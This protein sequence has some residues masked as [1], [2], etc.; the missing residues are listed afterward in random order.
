[1][2]VRRL[3]GGIGNQFHQYALGRAMQARGTDVI[4]ST[5][6]F[7]RNA[8]LPRPFRLDRFHTILETASSS[9]KRGK[10][11][12]VAERGRRFNSALTKKDEIVVHGYWQN[13][14]YHEN[15]LP[16]LRKELTVREE[17]Y[18]D[19]F[20]T[21]HKKILYKEGIGMHIRRGDFEEAELEMLKPG[22]YERAVKQLPDRPIFIFSDD[23]NW[24]K[25]NFYAL[26]N[27]TYVHLEDYLDFELLRLCKYK[28]IANSTFSWWAAYLGADFEQVVFRPASP[29]LEPGVKEYEMDYL[30]EWKSC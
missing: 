3:C 26:E 28:V 19:A 24:C 9:I 30:K 12:R 10:N 5:T 22:Y 27:V 20:N 25:V 7:N 4:Y 6:W 15:T 11:G 17:F 21:L 8:A 29:K 2:N 16:E 1:M 14:K 23:I 18:T 13:I